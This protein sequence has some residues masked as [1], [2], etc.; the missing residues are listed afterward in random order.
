MFQNIE[1]RQG[2]KL[3][4]EGAIEAL[5]DRFQK[6]LRSYYEVGSHVARSDK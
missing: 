3:F 6:T 2:L 1:E 4:L 5:W